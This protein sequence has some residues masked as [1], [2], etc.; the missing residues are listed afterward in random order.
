VI[1]QY[2]V[3]NDHTV[4]TTIDYFSYFTILSNILVAVTYT[5]AALAPESR[6]G[7]FLLGPPAALATVV[8]ITVTGITYYLLLASLYDL[9]GWTKTFDHLLHYV[10]PPSFIVFWLVIIPKGTLQFRSVL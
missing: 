5:V 8:Y 4:A 3:S 6:L 2:V 10:I 1:G 7:R 9:S